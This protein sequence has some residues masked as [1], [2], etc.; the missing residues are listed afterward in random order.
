MRAAPYAKL[1][2][3]AK[4][5]SGG[6]VDASEISIGGTLVID[7][8]GS[9]VGPTMTVNWNDI[10]GVP[11]DLL[12]GDDDTLMAISC[13][14]GQVLAWNGAT[15]GC[16]QD[17]GLTEAEVESFVTNGPLDFASGSMVDGEL[18]VTTGS[19]QDSLAALQCLNGETVK[20]DPVLGWACGSDQDTSDWNALPKRACRFG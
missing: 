8:N 4:N 17:N 14:P 9:W 11:S 2:L 5:V 10:V 1:A 13:Q 15:W 20:Y 7:A 3:D 16:A 19:D 6:T 18:I 12:D